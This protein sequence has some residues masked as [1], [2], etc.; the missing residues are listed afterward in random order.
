MKVKILQVSIVALIMIINTPFTKGS[1]EGCSISDEDEFLSERG[2]ERSILISWDKPTKRVGG[3]DLS[4][5]EIKGYLIIGVALSQDTKFYD[6]MVTIDP[7]NYQLIDERTEPQF[8]GIENIEPLQIGD[9]FQDVDLDFVAFVTCGE[10][11]TL[12]LKNMSKDI[13]SFLLS[14]KDTDGKYSDFTEIKSVA[15]P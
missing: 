4:S 11:P 6:Y 13:Y 9:I 2:G 1:D 14:T 15:I 12:L 10:K 3:K 5:G 7:D 8:P